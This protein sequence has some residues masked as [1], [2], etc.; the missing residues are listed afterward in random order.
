MQVYRCRSSQVYEPPSRY[1]FTIV[2]ATL[3][4]FGVT[5][6]LCLAEAGSPR[7]LFG[8]PAK[9]TSP[10][11]R[12]RRRGNVALETREREKTPRARRKRD[13]VTGYHVVCTGTQSTAC[14]THTKPVTGP[15]RGGTRSAAPFFGRNRRYS[16]HRVE[17]RL[18]LIKNPSF[19]SL[20][21]DSSSP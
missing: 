15:L 1:R 11:K 5:M 2:R 9:S 21:L 18:S 4:N 12:R 14:G 6:A 13:F 8:D 17:I 16:V 10:R 3:P 19:H 20:Q 7:F